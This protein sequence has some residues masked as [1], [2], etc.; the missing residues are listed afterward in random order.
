[1]SEQTPES[2]QT[3]LPG[4]VERA[5]SGF[6]NALDQGINAVLRQVIRG[7]LAVGDAEA[8][9]QD[10]RAAV[11]EAAERARHGRKRVQLA[12]LEVVEAE[13]SEQLAGLRALAEAEN[14]KAIVNDRM[15]HM[16]DTLNRQAAA[17]DR[18]QGEQQAALRDAFEPLEAIANKL[19][20]DKTD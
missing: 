17:M 2:E 7:Q 18:L 5:I 15:Q 8:A 1:M 20:G 14:P 12:M 3:S 10:V 19:R 9:M 4:S 13:V 11:A 6:S 16:Q